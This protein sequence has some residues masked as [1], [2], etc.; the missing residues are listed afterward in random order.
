MEAFYH[1]VEE[2]G[3]QAA[4]VILELSSPPSAVFEFMESTSFPISQSW[5]IAVQHLT[6]MISQVLNSQRN[7]PVSQGLA[8]SRVMLEFA[9][10]KTTS[11]N[12]AQSELWKWTVLNMVVVG[13]KSI[14]CM[15]FSGQ[16]LAA[17]YV[18][19]EDN[20]LHTYREWLKIIRKTV[21]ES[22]FV[23]DYSTSPS[24]RA[25][26]AVFTLS[27]YVLRHCTLFPVT[28]LLDG[29]SSI[30][31][32]ELEIISK[33]VAEHPRIGV[34]P[35]SFLACHFQCYFSEHPRNSK[36]SVSEVAQ[37]SFFNAVFKSIFQHRDSR[38]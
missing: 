38:C 28:Q 13:F 31:S 20:G 1:S 11:A 17:D 32:S 27:N 10:A 19:T 34:F 24:I 22:R 26:I 5:Q 4:T 14:S 16:N 35:V 2:L 7:Q 33:I 8:V 9:I 36:Q 6:S 21:F 37:V 18:V 12:H 3:M 29:Y 15:E 30:P 25:C 23:D